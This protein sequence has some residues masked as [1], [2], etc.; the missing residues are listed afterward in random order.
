MLSKLHK[1]QK[2]NRCLSTLGL[3]FGFCFSLFLKSLDWE[4]SI[5]IMMENLGID[6]ISDT[7]LCEQVHKAR[8]FMVSLLLAHLVIYGQQQLYLTVKY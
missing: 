8:L 4:T 5:S 7:H 6:C 3:A 1:W 2:A